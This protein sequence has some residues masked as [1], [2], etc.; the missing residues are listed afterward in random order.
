M[1]VTFPAAVFP[2]TD[3]QSCL[4]RAEAGF[5]IFQF[6]DAKF[7]NMIVAALRCCVLSG[8]IFRVE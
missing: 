1:H 5:A 4:T 2:F 6:A 3:G 7:Q 8:G